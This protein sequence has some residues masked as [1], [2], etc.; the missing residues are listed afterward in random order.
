MR[1]LFTKETA[2]RAVTWATVGLVTGMVASA[3]A[4]SVVDPSWTALVTD[5]SGA[6]YVVSLQ[7]RET[8]LEARA[9]ELRELEEALSVQREWAERAL[10][11]AESRCGEG[12]ANG[13]LRDSG[14]TSADPESEDQDNTDTGAPENAED[15]AE[16]GTPVLSRQERLRQLSSRVQ[17]MNPGAAA[18]L[19]TELP[20]GLATE[21]LTAIN[22]R[23]SGKI[24]DQLP[25]AVAARLS[26][27]IVE[28]EL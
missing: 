12:A 26:E 8:E 4:Q 24:L 7:E 28:D 11:E 20:G 14:E 9:E 16:A 19:L 15:A 22:A 10:A 23:A 6:A 5:G 17:A 18:A 3:G 1:R 13:D 25:P 27:R 2:L 21:V